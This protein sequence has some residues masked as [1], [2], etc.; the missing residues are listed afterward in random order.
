MTSRRSRIATTVLPATLLLLAAIFFSFRLD[1]VW[2]N[3]DEGQYLYEAWRISEGDLPYRDFMTA[4][5]P[6]FLYLG[7]LIQAVFGG[8]GL[9][10]RI[11]TVVTGLA[12][13]WGVWLLGRRVFNP[14]VAALAVL[15]F[16][17][18]DSVYEVVRVFRSDPYMLLWGIVGLQA[19]VAAAE[20]EGPERRRFLIVAG[21][22]FGLSANFKLFG[23]LYMGGA[24]LYLLVEAWRGRRGWRSLLSDLLALGIP[25]GLLLLIT[26]GLFIALT[27][28]FLERT[29]G[30]HLHQG[31]E[32]GLI[33]TLRKNVRFFDEYAHNQPLVLLLAALGLALAIRLRRPGAWALACQVPTMAVFMGLSRPLGDRH[34]VYVFPVL[35]LMWALALFEGWHRLRA[36][37]GRWRIAAWGGGIAIAALTVASLV[38]YVE[39]DLPRLLTVEHDTPDLVALI[40]R[41]SPPGSAMVSDYQGLNFYARRPGTYSS[42]GISTGAAR[43]GQITGERLIAEMDAADVQMVILEMGA[44]SP[45]LRSMP[46]FPDFYRYVQASYQLIATR[47][48]S[49]PRGKQWLEIYSKTD[50]LK[51]LSGI[52][53]GQRLAVTG[54]QLE[55]APIQAGEML[56]VTLRW[57]GL[58]PMDVGHSASVKLVDERGHI[59]AQQD[60]EI[61]ATRYRER[62]FG[63]EL[64]PF[65]TDQWEVGQVALQ[66]IGMPIPATTPPGRYRIEV[67]AYETASRRPITPDD[68][69]A[70]G[71]RGAEIAAVQVTRPAAAPSPAELPIAEAA[72]GEWPGLRLLGAGPLPERA[73]PGDRLHFSLFWE[74]ISAPGAGREALITL[75]DASGQV[76]AETRWPLAGVAFPSSEWRAGDVWLGQYE[77][78]VPPEATQG[79]YTLSIGVTGPD[80]QRPVMVPLRTIPVAGRQRLF[81]LPREPQAKAEAEFGSFARLLGYDLGE[82]A[83]QMR[84]TLY[85]QAL[86]TPELSYTVF[87]HLLDEH[88]ALIAQHDGLPQGGDSPT[89]GWVAGEIVVDEHVL[90]LP[91]GVSTAG[92]T[93][94]VGLYDGATLQR[95]PLTGPPGVSGDAWRG[96]LETPS[97]P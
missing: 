4:Q 69:A 7:A 74:A 71:F 58:A 94:E 27:P 38:P 89:S 29:V 64:D 24:G 92:W 19:L 11:V 57:V 50:L 12:A 43:S 21:G 95:V 35:A 51:P 83:G 41:A 61:Y 78:A 59:W 8:S 39:R 10:L 93:L 30:H 1:G 45:R 96:V 67:T 63:P 20:R 75:A 46:D 90:P 6:A 87:V 70:A 37:R 15:A 80:Q 66:V 79:E 54:Y 2:I 13:T 56:T 26:A 73:R 76:I 88:N 48:W 85:W 9:P 5:M 16:A 65:R 33:G 77:I 36:L 52:S 81:E 53:F 17:V 72:S 22:C 3:D 34:V 68:R 44:T 82:A 91:A 31:S 42:S 47:P 14:W 25:F 32:L 84:V 28:N 97:S 23:A 86:A 49:Y 60:K 18:N 62:Y 55:R 40:E